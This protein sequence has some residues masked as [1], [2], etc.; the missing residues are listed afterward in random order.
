[1]TIKEFAVA[2]SKKKAKKRKAK[3]ARKAAPARA[4]KKAATKKRAAKSKRGVKKTGKTAKRVAKKASK[5]AAKKA[6]RKSGKKAAKKVAKRA[7]KKTVAKKA[8]AAPKKASTVDRTSSAEKAPKAVAPRAVASRPVKPAPTPKPAPA[9]APAAERN[10]YFITTAIAYPNGQ[11]HIGH[12]YEAIATDALARFAR[13]DG[14]DVFFLTG[15]DEHGLKMIQAAEAEKLPTL[16]VATRN[17]LRFKE[18]D[19]R[20]NVSFDRFIR[21]TDPVHQRGVQALF[22]EIQKKGFIYKGKYTGQYCVFDELYVDVVGKGAPCPECGRPTETV[23]EENYYFK[24]SAF[25][26]KLL[27]HINQNPDFIRPETRRN[28]VVA[29]I[30]SGLRDLS[31]SRSSFKWGIP[32]P[33]DPKHVIYVWMDA[34][35]NYITALGWGS[36]EGPTRWQRGP[37]GQANQL[38]ESLEML[39]ANRTR[40]KVNGVWWF[41][42]T[43]EGGTCQ[44]CGSA[45]LLNKHYEAKP[46]WYRFVEWTGGKPDAVPEAAVLSE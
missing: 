36:E 15:T 16:E 1:M 4:G 26:D 19:Q 42:W 34:L 38:A 30:K 9:A 21:T 44:F 29:F 32:V 6:P 41:T 20:L 23:S 13:L 40:W 10:T 33:G 18:M 39:S 8:V 3:K 7:A 45:G 24:L 46:S 43:D 27:A 35:A 28:E 12:A 25:A 17:S 31:V 2:T 22:K 5:K 11:P 37:E 14:K